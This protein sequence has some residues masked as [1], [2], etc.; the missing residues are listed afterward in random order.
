[1]AEILS[2]RRKNN[3]L[4]INLIEWRKR[5]L[6]LILCPYLKDYK[7]CPFQFLSINSTHL[8]DMFSVCFSGLLTVILLFL[9]LAPETPS[10]DVTR[11]SRS[12]D[13][14]VL[15]LSPPRNSHDVIDQYEIHYCSEEQKSLEIEVCWYEANIEIVISFISF[16][17]RANEPNGIFYFNNSKCYQ[18]NSFQNNRRWN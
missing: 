16:V 18:W 13:T 6:L 1:M 5:S 17:V 9:I 3:H 14:V 12:E 2:I 8:K 15:V 7:L 10:V 4:F 11:C